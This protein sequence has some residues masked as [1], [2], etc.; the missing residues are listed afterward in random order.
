MKNVFEELRRGGISS[1]VCIPDGG[2]PPFYEV[3][4][5]SVAAKK[6]VNNYVKPKDFLANR[7]GKVAFFASTARMEKDK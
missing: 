5:N 4:Q 6:E 7:K 2:F 3:K 1:I